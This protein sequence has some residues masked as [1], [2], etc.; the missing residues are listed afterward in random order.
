MQTRWPYCITAHKW[1]AGVATTSL[2]AHT[3]EGGFP[4]CLGFREGTI[5][6][7]NLGGT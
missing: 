5:L 7:Y 6:A 2:D 1:A 4:G 3:S